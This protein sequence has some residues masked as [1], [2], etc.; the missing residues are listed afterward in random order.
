MPSVVQW[1]LC[2]LNREL[3][4]SAT[5]RPSQRKEAMS[6]VAPWL[7]V[8]GEAGQVHPVPSREDE[9]GFGR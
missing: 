1:L 6:Q 8:L 9:P 3:A 5:A 7:A 4:D 2:W